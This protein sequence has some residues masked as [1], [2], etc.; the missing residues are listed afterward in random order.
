MGVAALATGHR[1]ELDL[2]SVTPTIVAG[3]RRVVRTMLSFWALPGPAVDAAAQV[4]TELVTNV[5]EHTEE[6]ACSLWLGTLGE[7]LRVEVQD[8][9]RGAPLRRIGL[10]DDATGGRGLLLVQALSTAW[11]V[12]RLPF[13]KVVWSEMRASAEVAC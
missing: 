11:G 8:A 4:V 12:E 5:Y 1:F 6:R 9:G 13:G 10:P 3:T 7:V 2:P